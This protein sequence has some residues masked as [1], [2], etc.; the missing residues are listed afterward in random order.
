MVI[1]TLRGGSPGIG[2]VLSMAVC[3]MLAVG[4]VT[5]LKPVISFIQSLQ[6]LTGMDSQLITVLLKVVGISVTAEIACLL[7]EDSGNGALGKALQILA[8][9][10]I[11][12]LSVPVLT[13]LMEL[14]GGLLQNL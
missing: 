6:S 5:L 9:A 8:T 10:V 3:V 11:L 14:I 4:A 7:C 12:C 13:A 1:L 2:Q